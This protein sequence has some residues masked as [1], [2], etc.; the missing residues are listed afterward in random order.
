MRGLERTGF[1]IDL[2]RADLRR[3]G[4]FVCV[5]DLED[6]LI[7]CLGT[8]AV[9]DAVAA[10]G[11]LR[12]LQIVMRQPAQRDRTP[13]EVIHRF[14]GTR[15]GRKLAYARLLV[16]ALRQDATPPPLADLLTHIETVSRMPRP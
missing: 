16:D 2:Q 5:T 13:D 11:D 14:I 4:F 12:S 15:S 9:M 1:G 6:E 3:H 10:N 8:D 7:R